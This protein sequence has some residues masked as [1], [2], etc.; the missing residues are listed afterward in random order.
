MSDARRVLDEAV[1]EWAQSKSANVSVGTHQYEIDAWRRLTG[2][3]SVEHMVDV[4]CGA[5]LFDASAVVVEF[6]DRATGIDPTEEAHGTARSELDETERLLADLGLSERVSFVRGYWPEVSVPDCDLLVFRSALHHILESEM[7]RRELVDSLQVARSSL[8]D[9]GHVYIRET[10]PAKRLQWYAQQVYRHTRG[11]GSLSADGKLSTERWESLL[12]EA[13]YSD[14]QS[15]MLP[16]NL[17]IDSRL[18][19][20]PARALS[21]SCLVTGTAR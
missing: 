20:A 18:P 7:S 17:F 15:T 1:R 2:V 9:G 5:G 4:G 11:T 10:T 14:L 16:P 8:G 6:A 13:G 12:A 3:E 19:S 21:T